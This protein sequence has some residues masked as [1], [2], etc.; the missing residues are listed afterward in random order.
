MNFFTDTVG[1]L[2]KLPALGST[3]GSGNL[4]LRTAITA[5]ATSSAVGEEIRRL[6]SSARRS[7]YCSFGCHVFRQPKLQR[8]YEIGVRLLLKETVSVA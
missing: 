1:F 3:A 6:L 2:K 7:S 8:V 4:L 5:S